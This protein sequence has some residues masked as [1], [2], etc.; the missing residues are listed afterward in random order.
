MMFP[1]VLNT[2]SESLDGLFKTIRFSGFPQGASVLSRRE[3]QRSSRPSPPGRSDVKYTVSPSAVRIAYISL[4]WVLSGG[5]TLIGGDHAP[6]WLR[7]EVDLP[8]PSVPGA[9]EYQSPSSVKIKIPRL[10]V[11]VRVDR[12][13]GA[14]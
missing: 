13:M 3:I 11:P 4:Y 8:L 7:S 12:V 14:S 9:A 10:L 2:D 5:P 1:E 6:N